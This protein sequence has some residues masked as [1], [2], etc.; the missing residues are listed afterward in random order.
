MPKI[1]SLEVEQLMER[2]YRL[3]NIRPRSE[4]EI[5]DYLRRLSISTSMVDIVLARLKQLR[6]LND[7]QFAKSWIEA[8]SKK[9]GMIAI[10]AELYRKGISKEIIDGVTNIEINQEETAKKLLEKRLPRI[11]SRKQAYEFLMR[12]GFEYEIVAQVIEKI[13]KKR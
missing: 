5:T 7:E 12:R 8:R 11:R 4:K 1:I 3:W 6:L 10:K 2:M 13:L 9:K